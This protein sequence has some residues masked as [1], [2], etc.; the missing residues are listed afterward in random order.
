MKIRVSAALKAKLTAWFAS[1]SMLTFHIQTDSLDEAQNPGATSADSKTGSQNTG[2][3]TESGAAKPPRSSNALRMSVWDRFKD[4]FSGLCIHSKHSQPTRRPATRRNGKPSPDG[5]STASAPASYGSEAAPVATDPSSIG[6]VRTPSPLVNRSG[7][8][9]PSS[10]ASSVGAASGPLLTPHLQPPPPVAPDGAGAPTP[11]PG[12]A[13][14]FAPPTIRPHPLPMPLLSIN[15]WNA[16]SASATG[17]PYSSAPYFA[18]PS[19][20]SGRR[21][22]SI[23]SRYFPRE[24]WVAVY[25]FLSVG[26][27]AAAAATCRLMQSLSGDRAVWRGITDL[28]LMGNKMP[29]TAQ[30]GKVFDRLPHL[31][32]LSFASF[33]GAVRRRLLLNS[34]SVLCYIA[35]ACPNL[36][37]VNLYGFSVSDVGVNAFAQHCSQLSELFLSQSSISDK[38]LQTIVSACRLQRLSL[39]H[40]RHLT[41]EGLRCLG[42][43]PE[44]SQLSLSDTAVTDV[45]IRKGIVACHSLTTLYLSFTLVTDVGLRLLTSLP[46]LS[47]LQLQCCSRISDTGVW[48]V[49]NLCRTLTDLDISGNPQ[50]TDEA[51]A[52]F[53]ASAVKRLTIS[54][55]PNITLSAR[56]ALSSGG[57]VVMDDPEFCSELVEA[58]VAAEVYNKLELLAMADGYASVAEFVR[59]YMAAF[60]D[61]QDRKSVV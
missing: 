37:S 6:G 35:K 47:T 59:V 43:A 2:A 15:A 4:W 17:A 48:D 34:D 21:P 13:P 28:R 38:G 40:C 41:D 58:E 5:R 57:V 3:A 53:G 30:I 42:D 27:F 55:C 44:L 1:Q 16:A 49:A 7:I 51:V 56:A 45:A 24:V 31:T 46:V 14:F 9:A 36:T 60:L 50:L 29:A 22:S 52:E 18:M 20:V 8:V 19:G 61:Q 11:V 26:E 32:L 23:T 39:A 25:R 10:A 12:V 33:S 54:S